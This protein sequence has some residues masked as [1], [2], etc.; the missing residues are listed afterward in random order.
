MDLEQQNRTRKFLR[1][2]KSTSSGH[3][4]YS[5]SSNIENI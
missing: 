2:E 3:I 5:S 4:Q 1:T